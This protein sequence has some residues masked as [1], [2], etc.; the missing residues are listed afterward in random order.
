MCQR[1]GANKCRF[2]LVFNKDPGNNVHMK[3]RAFA[4]IYWFYP[5]MKFTNTADS[6]NPREFVSHAPKP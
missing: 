4:S 3:L 1:S 2:G 6:V 5:I